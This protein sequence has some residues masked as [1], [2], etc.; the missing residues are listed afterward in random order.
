MPASVAD[1]S[2][3]AAIAFG[4]ENSDEAVRLLREADLVEPALLAYELASVARK[5][6]LKY[7]AQRAA[8]LT[9]LDRALQLDIHWVDVDHTAVVE[10][11]VSTGLST[12]DASYVWLARAIGAPLLTFDR[13]L[14]AIEEP[15]G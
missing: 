1:A 12:Y 15:R 3:I 11:A 10:L 7:P 8:I 5:K 9:A 2:V 14:L 13:R 6:L 4:E